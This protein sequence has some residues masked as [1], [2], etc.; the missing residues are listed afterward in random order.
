MSAGGANYSGL[1][2]DHA[3]RH[4]FNKDVVYGSPGRSHSASVGGMVDPM[5]G[6]PMH[7]DP[8]RGGGGGMGVPRGMGHGVNDTR[9][10]QGMTQGMHPGMY[11]MDYAGGGASSGRNYSMHSQSSGGAASS[12]LNLSMHSQSSSDG[13]GGGTPHGTHGG[14]GPHGGHSFHSSR[15]TPFHD[16]RMH[17][18]GYPTNRPDTGYSSNRADTG[19]SMNRYMSKSYPPAPPTDY[20]GSGL[21]GGTTGMP[22]SPDHQLRNLRRGSASTYASSQQMGTER[23]SVSDSASTSGGLSG[24]SLGP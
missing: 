10:T 12:G 18:D 3:H 5:H 14:H 20:S 11:Q 8:Y 15:Q 6:D 21:S 13:S 7:G 16:Q 24:G 1:N 23:R 17:S 2:Q 19:A 9:M 22:M 4:G